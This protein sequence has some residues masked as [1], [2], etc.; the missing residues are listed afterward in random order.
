MNMNFGIAL[1]IPAFVI[2]CLLQGQEDFKQEYKVDVDSYVYFEGYTNV[3]FKSNTSA[4][5]IQGTR[6]VFDEFLDSDV[7]FSNKTIAPD[8]QMNYDCYFDQVVF[9]NDDGEICAR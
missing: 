6:F 9:S 7:Y 4:Y 2:P 3:R 1:A 5:G 8:R